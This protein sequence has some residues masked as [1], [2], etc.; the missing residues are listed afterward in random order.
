MRITTKAPA[1]FTMSAAIA[2]TASVLT[3]Q[4][5]PQQP[6]AK[7]G[8]PPAARAPRPD[9]P[10]PA[11]PDRPAAEATKWLENIEIVRDV[12]Y[13][14]IDGEHGQRELLLDAAFPRQAGDKPLPAI[15]YIHGGG[16]SGGSRDAG[17]PFT[18]AFANGGYVAVTISYRLSGEATYPAAV[19]DCKA[20]VRFLRAHADELGIDPDRI[21]VWGHSAGGHL[22]ALIGLTGD[23]KALEGNVGETGVSSRVACFVSVSGPSDLSGFEYNNI[24]ASFLGGDEKERA[25]RATEASPVSHIDANDPPALIVHGTADDL[26][27]IRQGQ[28]LHD[29]LT[30]AGVKN[31]FVKVEGAGHAIR[32]KATYEKIAAFFDAQLGGHA[33]KVL[34][35][36][37]LERLNDAPPPPSD[38]PDRPRRRTPGAAGDR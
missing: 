2:L 36:V 3:A 5:P 17:L 6:G 24:V 7:P 35:E 34:A 18:I 28:L 21:G 33:A 23:D 8:A 1:M 13:A 38:R 11:P 9:A 12:V 29:K 30:A 27:N 16:W 10:P 15:I 32:D 20:A 19:H 22:S 4:A 25:T 26:V 31:E 37:D 14:T